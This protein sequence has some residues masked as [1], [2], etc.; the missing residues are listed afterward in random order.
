MENGFRRKGRGEVF[1]YKN[2]NLY[3]IDQMIGNEKKGYKCIEG[4][5]MKHYEG[6]NLVY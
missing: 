1:L 2:R 6:N 4:K 3:E 5:V